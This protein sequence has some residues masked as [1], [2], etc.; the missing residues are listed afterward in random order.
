MLRRLRNLWAW[1]DL[2]PERVKIE[3]KSPIGDRLRIPAKIISST[4]PA[5]ELMQTIREENT[6]QA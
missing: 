2:T 4:D 5:D 3:G 6:G 1:S